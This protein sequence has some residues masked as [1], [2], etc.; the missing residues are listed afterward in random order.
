M[1]T[2][3]FIYIKCRCECVCVCMCVGL[4]QYWLFHSANMVKYPNACVFVRLRYSMFA[5]PNMIVGV[6]A[7]GWEFDRQDLKRN[8][9]DIFVTHAH[10]A[11]HKHKYFL[12][13]IVFTFRKTKQHSCPTFRSAPPRVIVVN[14][15]HHI[16]CMY[17]RIARTSNLLW[18][19][20]V[21]VW[22]DSFHIGRCGL[23]ATNTWHNL[24]TLWR[25]GC[26]MSDA[27][28]SFFRQWT[29]GMQSVQRSLRMQIEM[30]P[31]ARLLVRWP[32]TASTA[33]VM[34]G[35]ISDSH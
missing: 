33:A 21:P 4:S 1:L 10:N 32:A 6:S 35:H 14:V 27:N 15:Y 30:L 2:Y 28:G 18:C 3:F 16:H 24:M 22:T 5:F 7:G 19:V 13:A 34:V 8:C 23:T 17:V 9:N 20:K 26:N 29:N 25:R 11:I 12:I 31:F